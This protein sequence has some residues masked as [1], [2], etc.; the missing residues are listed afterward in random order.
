VTTRLGSPAWT[1]SA[2]RPG[3]SGGTRFNNEPAGNTTAVPAFELEIAARP[4]EVGRV[5][6][7]IR[8]A[9]VRYGLD[10]SHADVT[11]LIASELVMN[12]V[13]HGEP[14]VIV[15]LSIE[16]QTTVLEVYDGGP[17]LPVMSPDDDPAHARRG[18]RV[19][20]GMCTDWGTVPDQRGG[21]TVWCAIS[22]DTTPGEPAR[23][24]RRAADEPA[25]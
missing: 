14:P 12:A 5:R 15:R 8:A 1:A 23:R 22:N 19:V 4:S 16:P 24:R 2:E 21:K 13:L 20:E 10:D 3:S 18:L 25:Y 7:A 6:R 17:G 11:Q 9:V